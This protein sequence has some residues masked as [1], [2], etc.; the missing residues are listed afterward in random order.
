MPEHPFH[1]TPDLDWADEHIE[2]FL[3]GEL[4]GSDRDRFQALLAAEPWLRAEVAAARRIQQELASIPMAVC[5][6]HVSRHILAHA[7][8]DWWTALPRRLA[9]GFRRMAQAGL[10]PALAMALLLVVVL[11]STLVSRPEAPPAVASADVSQALAD[12][13]MA[14]GVLADAGRTTGTAVGNDVI[15]PLV[16][17]PVARSM[18]P[19]SQN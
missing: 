1:P 15:G 19:L 5:P 4:A 9:D 2:S 10:R 13:K 18:Q 17:R 11:S 14:L 7:R 8:H 12:V 6:D 3:D 16:V